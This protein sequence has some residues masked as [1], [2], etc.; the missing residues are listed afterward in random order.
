MLAGIIIISSSEGVLSKPGAQL[1]MRHLS[2]IDLAGGHQPVFNEDG[3][4]GIVLIGEIYNFTQCATSLK[5]VAIA[6]ARV[7]IPKSSSTP[8]KSGARPV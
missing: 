6:S 1:G 3:T 7:P 4:V 2:I 8:T 5:K